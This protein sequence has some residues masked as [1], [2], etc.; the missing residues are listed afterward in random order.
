MPRAT[1]KDVARVAGVSDGTVS[2]ALRRPGTV[3]A[4][5]RE[6]VLRAVTEVGYVANAAA[7]ALRAGR[8]KSLGLAVLGFGNP[9]FVDIADAAEEA[10]LAAGGLI[11]IYNTARDKQREDSLLRRLQ[12]RQLDGLIITPLD[13]DDP[14]LDELVARGTAVVVLLRPVPSGRHCTV[15][16]DDVATGRLA[17]Q[18]LLDRGHRRIAYAGP[19]N[20]E[21]YEGA[22]AVAAPE[23]DAFEWRRTESAEV[24][25]GLVLAAQIAGL[26]A[27][28]RPTAV[29][30]E[31]D[32]LAVGLVQGA[33]RHG[34]RV[35]DDL[36][37]VGVDDT[38][39]ASAASAVGLTTVRQ[40]GAE[41]ARA[42]VGLLVEEMAQGHDIHRD[43][44][45]E[46]ELVVR[47]SSGPRRSQ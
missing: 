16:V 1:I 47:A 38:P 29:F 43:V 7:R 39:L 14:L 26:S 34:L 32:L 28:E 27:G 5:T 35:P 22:L 20:E 25:D 10:A 6:R 31:N 13:V 44:V 36:A 2:N 19:V 3:S 30:C 15:R 41:M 45:F 18:H 24:D 21:R 23:V 9:F 4:A 11:S 37:V 42:A 8:T 46:P 33:R 17:T 40:P 12:E